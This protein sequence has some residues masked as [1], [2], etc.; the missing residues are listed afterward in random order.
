M[1]MGKV[2]EKSWLTKKKI[3]VF[4]SK[5]DMYDREYYEANRERINARHRENYAKHRDVWNAKRRSGY[6]RKRE[7]L[8]KKQREDR[9]PCP[10]C[11]LTFRRSYVPRHILLRHKVDSM[12]S[13]SRTVFAACPDELVQDCDI[14]QPA[15]E[16][17]HMSHMLPSRVLLQVGVASCRTAPNSAEYFSIIE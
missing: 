16:S 10:L 8:L 6:L 9:A 5:P 12:P 7:C 2:L 4:D 14:S 1:V 11:H 3:G 13:G 17:R 15:S